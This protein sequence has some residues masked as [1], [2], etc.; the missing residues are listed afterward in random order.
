MLEIPL[1][2]ED[3]HIY[4]LASGRIDEST[5]APVVV[6][7]VREDLLPSLAGG[8]KDPD[9][10]ARVKAAMAAAAA[11]QAGVPSVSAA[12]ALALPLSE[13]FDDP[14]SLPYASQALREL[15]DLAVPFL[16]ENLNTSDPK[17]RSQAVRA[18]GKL[19]TDAKDALP[20]L[21]KALEDKSLRDT[22]AE[23]LKNIIAAIIVSKSMTVGEAGLAAFIECLKDTSDEWTRELAAKTLGDL[24]P[25]AKAAI[26]A[27]AEAQKSDRSKQVRNAAEKALKK[28]RR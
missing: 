6:D 2:A 22:T 9:P 23:T 20:S 7:M 5:W 17:L 25:R 13:M 14:R 21:M 26:P 10:Y 28:I 16:L 15:G 11:L 8:L 27:L 12:S 1:T 3:G 18:L 19:E 24:G 4:V